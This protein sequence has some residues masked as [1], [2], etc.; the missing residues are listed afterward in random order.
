[1]KYFKSSSASNSS[2]LNGEKGLPSDPNILDDNSSISILRNKLMNVTNA[3]LQEVDGDNGS[4][5]DY[6]IN[7]IRYAFNACK[8]NSENRAI[9]SDV[10]PIRL[11]LDA[12]ETA[13]EGED[14]QAADYAFHVA[15][16]KGD[17][18]L[19]KL[20]MESVACVEN[21]ILEGFGLGY[22]NLEDGSEASFLYD[23]NV[24]LVEKNPNIDGRLLIDAVTDMSYN[25]Y[26]IANIAMQNVNN[27]IININQ[28]GIK[29][30]IGDFTDGPDNNSDIDFIASLPENV[31][32]IDYKYKELDGIEL[33]TRD[34]WEEIKRKLEPNKSPQAQA[35]LDAGKPMTPS[36]FSNVRSLHSN[37]CKSREEFVA[38]KKPD[39]EKKLISGVSDAD[40]EKYVKANIE[41]IWNNLAFSSSKL[42][43]KEFQGFLRNDT[44]AISFAIKDKKFGDIAYSSYALMQDLKVFVME[45]FLDVTS[46]VNDINC[47]ELR[48]HMDKLI[49]EVV[50]LN[51]EDRMGNLI[52]V[53]DILK[54]YG[55]YGS[56]N[57]V[58]FEE[59]LRESMCSPTNIALLKKYANSTSRE[60]DGLTKVVNI[61]ASRIF[62]V[63]TAEEPP[64]P[65]SLPKEYVH[66]SKTESILYEESSIDERAIADE[67]KISRHHYKDPLNDRLREV[68]HLCSAL[69]YLH[70]KLSLNLNE[71]GLDSVNS[72][73]EIDTLRNVEKSKPLSIIREAAKVIE[74][75]YDDL[76]NIDHKPKNLYYADTF[77]EPD[78]SDYIESRRKFSEIA[79][80]TIYSTLHIL[81]SK[82]KDMP[83]MA[84]KSLSDDDCL[85]ES[86]GSVHK[87]ASN[88][89]SK[90]V[91]NSSH[92]SNC[93]SKKQ[94]KP[95]NVFDDGDTVLASG[96]SQYKTHCENEKSRKMKSGKKNILSF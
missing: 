71:A 9:Q 14:I 65:S 46:V 83:N 61:A 50:E 35:V 87:N 49:L 28:D 41:R 95:K 3:F 77:N 52:S 17:A 64:L 45:N 23:M 39:A 91:S 36:L 37:I 8:L 42:R 60:P 63:A 44:D 84:E 76:K 6:K 93:D 75:R 34:D 96:N 51:P 27:M 25:K 38:K 57:R 7:A 72:K 11:L 69:K 19:K 59:S 32:E 40:T 5:P 66:S 30:L 58:R 12:I 55:E 80:S 18:A 43:F 26:K 48:E 4:I 81:D 33:N 16:N 89:S 78:N 90:L 22:E 94:T 74:S 47:K 13:T 86:S 53:D 24:K 82:R 88:S 2:N 67:Y 15:N 20:A 62:D 68:R 21:T 31:F 56:P 10:S 1:M 85:P 92:A 29:G 54:S 70:E 73:S 79:L